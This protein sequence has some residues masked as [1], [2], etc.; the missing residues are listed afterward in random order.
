LNFAFIVGN[1]P[2]GTTEEQMKEYFSDVG[3]V[4]SFRFVNEKAA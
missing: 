2:H 1:I 4:L 3:T